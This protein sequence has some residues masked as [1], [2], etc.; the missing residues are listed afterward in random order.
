MGRPARVC[1]PR[2]DGRMIQ[3]AHIPHVGR[4]ALHSDRSSSHSR[5]FSK[6]RIIARPETRVS[7]QL[8]R[9]EAVAAKCRVAALWGRGRSISRRSYWDSSAQRVL[10]VTLGWA[11]P[12]KPFHR[13]SKESICLGDEASLP[14]FT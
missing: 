2:C 13:L 3:P 8:E 11:I 6:A 5:A 1:H 7:M 4:T 12:C 9:I 10:N 14:P